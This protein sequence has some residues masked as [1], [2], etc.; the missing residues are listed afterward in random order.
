MVSVGTW[1]GLQAVALAAVTA[2]RGAGAEG[3]QEGPAP[4]VTE[5]QMPQPDVQEPRLEAYDAAFI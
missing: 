1:A 4:G 2:E 3:G 5:S